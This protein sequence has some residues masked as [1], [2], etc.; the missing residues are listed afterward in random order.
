MAND[1][2]EVGYVYRP[3]G[4]VTMVPSAHEVELVDCA[5]VRCD[6]VHIFLKDHMGQPFAE[7]TLTERF[8]RE[9]VAFYIKREGRR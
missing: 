9:I 2:H 5:D 7:C 4:I 1:I 6:H 3:T 8:C